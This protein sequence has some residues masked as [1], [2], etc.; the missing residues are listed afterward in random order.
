MNA[1]DNCLLQPWKLRNWFHE[2]HRYDKT[3]FL[4]NVQ[5]LQC[6]TSFF[7]KMIKETKF[8]RCRELSPSKLIEIQLLVYSK[9]QHAQA[10]IIQKSELLTTTVGLAFQDKYSTKLCFYLHSWAWDEIYHH[11]FFTEAF[12]MTDGIIQPSENFCFFLL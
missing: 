9:P 11:P 12:P 4:H 2:N 6:H 5:V 7:L 3:L 1:S 8:T 10:I